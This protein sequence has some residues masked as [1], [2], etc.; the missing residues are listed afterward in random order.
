M[1]RGS[2]FY[3]KLNS[4]VRYLAHKMIK[5]LEKRKLTMAIFHVT[6]MEGKGKNEQ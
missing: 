5:G 4:T 3:S 6:I 1:L 2:N